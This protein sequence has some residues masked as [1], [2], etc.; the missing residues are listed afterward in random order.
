MKLPLSFSLYIFKKK[1]VDSLKKKTFLYKHTMIQSG[2]TQNHRTTENGQHLRR[3]ASPTPCSEADQLEQVDE[4]C[5]LSGFEYHQSQRLHNFSGSPF[6]HWTTP[7]VKNFFLMLKW[8][9]LY[10]HASQMYPFFLHLNF[11]F[12]ILQVFSSY[13]VHAN[14]ECNTC[15]CLL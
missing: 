1:P 6:Q 7:T 3:S 9:F 5:T 11:L 15:V 2:P 14:S 13:H 8:N 10:E 4:G 12:F